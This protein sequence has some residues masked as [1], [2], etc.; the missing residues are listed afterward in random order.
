MDSTIRVWDLE[1]GKS[2]SVI[3]ATPLE[4]WTLSF[5]PDS[6]YIATGS[7]S[8][9]VNIFNAETGKKEQSFDA[10][11]KTFCMC[12]AYVSIFLN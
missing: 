6:R 9:N 3:E 2:L 10:L 1:K 12:V 8:G 7:Q 11:K 4:A 5:S